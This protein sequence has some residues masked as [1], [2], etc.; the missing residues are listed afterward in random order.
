MSEL[1]DR[2]KK[3]K[4]N[5][6]SNLHLHVRVPGLI[7][8]LELLKRIQFYIHI[9]LPTVIDAVEPMETP[10]GEGDYYLAH[11]KRC[12]RRKVSHKKV[13]VQGFAV[14]GV[15][16]DGKSSFKDKMLL[17]FLND[18]EKTPAQI[19]GKRSLIKIKASLVGHDKS[20]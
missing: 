7:D 14:R 1:K 16:V 13:E 5:H 19:V 20:G 3:L 11:K 10:S 6:R 15:E 2:L 17:Y 8:N 4:S 18:E 12:K 9:L